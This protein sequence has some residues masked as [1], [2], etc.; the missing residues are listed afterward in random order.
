M[1]LPLVGIAAGVAA[2]AVAKKAVQTAAKKAATKK[3]AAANARGLKAAKKPT[4]KTG[5]KADRAQRAE[6]QGNANL[7]KNANPARANR[8]RGGSL[9][10]MKEYGG[11]GLATKKLTPRQ[12]EFR[13]DI[14]KELNPTR[15]TAAKPGSKRK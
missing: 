7:I 14:T 11:M 2:R 10:A 15:K 12:A 13:A 6:L 5:T 4:N 8:T 9:A 3:A 1:V